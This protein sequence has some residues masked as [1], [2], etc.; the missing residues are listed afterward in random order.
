MDLIKRW[1]QTFEKYKDKVAIEF[2]GKEVTFSEL[3]SITDKL[4]NG[5]KKLGVSK[6]DRCAQYT[7]NSLELI[8]YFLGVIKAGGILVPMNCSFKE[9]E[10]TY[11][12]GNSGAKILLTDKSRIPIIDGIKGD[13]SSLKEII[14]VDGGER[15]HD[16]HEIISSSSSD[17]TPDLTKDDGA[18]MFFTS[19]TTGQPKGALLSHWNIL[20]NLEALAEAWRWSSEDRLLIMLPLFHI[21]GLG[22]ALAGSFYNGNFFKLVK[23]FDPQLALEMIEKDRMTLFMGV[24]AMYCKILGV[25]GKEKYDVSS[26]R[27]FVSGSAPLSID[28]FNQ[29]KEVFGCEIL[30]RAGMSETNM[31]FSNPYDGKRKPGTVGFALKY[32][33]YK[34]VDRDFNDVKQGEEG[35]LLLKGDNVFSGYWNNPT[36][37]EESFHDGWFITGDVAKEDSEGYVWFVSR[38]KDV[39]ISGGLNIYPREIEN[40][41]DEHPSIKE[42]AVVGVADDCFG[43]N[44]KAFVV[45]EDGAEISPEEVIQYCKDKVASY[46]KPKLVEFI[47]ELPRNAMGKVQKEELKKKD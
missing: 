40:V 42:T 25:E 20:S 9:K 4:A 45:L 7:Q 19:G 16:M 10:L 13:I 35:E 31:N 11:I 14:S 3:D 1:K 26:M 6:G 39:I 36:K 2:E 18:I 21:H 17:Y 46:K 34:I 12:L 44:V 41:L 23:K 43:E 28:T 47:S 30:E 32:V 27:L 29:F 33:E 38:S 24:P 5:L 37:T 22:V 15:V 8:Y